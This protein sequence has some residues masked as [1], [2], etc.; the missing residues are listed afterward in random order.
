[1]LLLIYGLLDPFFDIYMTSVNIYNTSLFVNIHLFII[2]IFAIMI[3][4]TSDQAIYRVRHKLTWAK[5]EEEQLQVEI[6][7]YFNSPFSSEFAC[8]LRNNM[9]R[10]NDIIFVIGGL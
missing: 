10:G 6:I 3:C 1:M 8:S 5:E 7:L 9:I 2:M 4:R